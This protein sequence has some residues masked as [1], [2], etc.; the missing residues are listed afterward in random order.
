MYKS[1]Y[2]AADLR[3]FL[4]DAPA[5]AFDFENAPDEKYR[6][7]EKEVLDAHKPHIVGSTFQ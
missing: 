7:Y 1:I 4:I 5:V 6:K 2:T 3:D